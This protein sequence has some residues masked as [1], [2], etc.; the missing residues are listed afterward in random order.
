MLSLSCLY[1]KAMLC[2]TLHGIL[3][4]KKKKKRIHFCGTFAY[5]P[6]PEAGGPGRSPWSVRA[7]QMKSLQILS[8][9]SVE[10]DWE[11]LAVSLC[12]DVFAGPQL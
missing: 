8:T 9:S 7:V 2:I 12:V 6:G 3:T 1:F 4:F 10:A 11:F 5:T